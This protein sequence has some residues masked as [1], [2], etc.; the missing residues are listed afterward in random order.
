MSRAAL[1]LAFS[2]HYL[3][4]LTGRSALPV[5][6]PYRS[7]EDHRSA[8]EALQQRL[9]T[10]R[11]PFSS[12]KLT[13]GHQ[14]RSVDGSDRDSILD[15]RPLSGILDFDADEAT[16]TVEPQVTVRQL[17]RATIADG[18]APAVLP[19]FPEITVGGAIQGLAAESTC[20]RHG[21]FHESVTT[22]EVLLGDGTHLRVTP[23]HHPE[24]WRMIPGSYGTVAAITAA[25]L[26]LIP[27]QPWVEL[28]HRRLSVGAFIDGAFDHDV[29]AVDAIAVDADH[30]VVTTARWIPAP[31]AGQPRRR[32]RRFAPYYADHV[33][34]AASED[35]SEIM[36]FEDY[37]F[38]FDRGAFWI[39]PTKLGRGL[40]SR[41]LLADF[42]TAANLYRLR[43]SRQRLRP[44]PSRRVVQDCMLPHDRVGSVLRWVRT[45]L[46]GPI[47]LLPILSRT[48]NP[49]GL[50]PGR[51]INLG[52]YLRH[53]GSHDGVTA[54]REEL[55]R[56]VVAAGGRKT[57]HAEVV[58]PAAYL[59]Q[60][61]DMAE[62]RQLRHRF[63]ADDAFPDLVAK[64]NGT[65]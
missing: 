31:P 63:A 42:A 34:A 40:L 7:D 43:R 35:A 46:E 21:L 32:F 5:E 22:M 20:H 44:G 56:R 8:I 30:A 19:E 64:L 58:D 14:A 38:R 47:W 49:F 16:I 53:P 45:H 13:A 57:L 11:P 26:R 10:G 15:L 3:R 37:A 17:V 27:A 60:T 24:L 59:E 1:M 18:W 12:R 50:Q 52:I 33:V 54:F 9:R 55:E 28:H 29:D 39:A 6:A 65:H 4:W 61:V 62:Y 2:G 25:T 36:S 48:E 23:D 51:W 41:A